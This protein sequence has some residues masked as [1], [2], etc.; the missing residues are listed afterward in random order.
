MDIKGLLANVVGLIGAIIGGFLGY[1]MNG[2]IGA[3]IGVVA[4]YFGA[5]IGTSILL[6]FMS[7]AFAMLSF[8][9]VLYIIMLVA[10][11]YGG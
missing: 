2:L 5:I 9:V 1:D 7:G 6:A 11:K 8:F 10:K 4:G 3:V